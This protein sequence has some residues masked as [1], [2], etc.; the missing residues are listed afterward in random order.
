MTGDF[1]GA[2]MTEQHNHAAGTFVGRDNY[3]P[4]ETLDPTTKEFLRKLAAQAP[5]LA[6][7]L[8]K[9]VRDGMVTEELAAQLSIAARSINEDVAGALLAASR[10]INPD[11]A[12]SF[13]GTGTRIRDG[14]EAIGIAV[15]RLEQVSADLSLPDIERVTGQ[16]GL[17]AGR[18]EAA[19]HALNVQAEQVAKIATSLGPRVVVSMKSLMLT[20]LLVAVGGFIVGY[21]AHTYM[22]HR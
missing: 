8:E 22:L 6:R 9:A 13:A 11:V 18:L 4:I 1:F 17:A 19:A 16:V 2:G 15:S 3:G 21:A 10:R 14:A 5:A 20:V 12:E 7:L